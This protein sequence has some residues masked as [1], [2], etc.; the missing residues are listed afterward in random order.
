MYEPGKAP[1][2]LDEL[3]DYHR[4]YGMLPIEVKLTKKHG[5]SRISHRYI[6]EG[7]L[8]LRAR[9]N[10]RDARL[11]Q[12]ALLLATAFTKA[13]GR[14]A[15]RGSGVAFNKFFS[16]LMQ[17]VCPGSGYEKADKALRRAIRLHK[18]MLAKLELRPPL[19]RE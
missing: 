2:M 14:P 10:P 12:L 11:E 15:G 13:T 18:A 4:L 6:G 1:V 5:K 8:E 17:D 9:G 3:S 7:H 16:D 19:Q